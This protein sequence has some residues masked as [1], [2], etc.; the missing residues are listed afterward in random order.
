MVPSFCRAISW[1][2]IAREASDDDQGLQTREATTQE[3]NTA[4]NNLPLSFNPPYMTA[5]DTTADS[6]Q[7][8]NGCQQ[9][10]CD[11]QIVSPS[12][13]AEKTQVS[14]SSGLHVVMDSQQPH[15]NTTVQVLGSEQDGITSDHQQDSSKVKDLRS[16]THSQKCLQIL[17]SLRKMWAERETK[18]GP[19]P[20]SV[21]ICRGAGPQNIHA[22]IS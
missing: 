12:F 16:T 7:T 13:I 3:E 21:Y 19:P 20:V 14:T 1:Q 18:Y 9:T 8:E 2:T 6:S 15:S 22:S 17:H 5:T 10:Q 11:I 4:A